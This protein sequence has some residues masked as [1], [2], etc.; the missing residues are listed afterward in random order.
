MWLPGTELQ[1]P[2]EKAPTPRQQHAGSWRALCTWEQGTQ[3]SGAVARQAEEGPAGWLLQPRRQSEGWLV[4][5]EPEALD[6]VDRKTVAM[7]H[8]SDSSDS[9]L[10]ALPLTTGRVLPFPP[11]PSWFSGAAGRGPGFLGLCPGTL[12]G[13]EMAGAS[14]R[15]KGC[16]KPCISGRDPHP[17][18][19]PARGC[20]RG[21]SLAFTSP[22]SHPRKLSARRSRH[23]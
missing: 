16:R 20:S 12:R 9:S 6:C 17:S 22:E 10:A 19:P 15:L 21:V 1:K 23:V 13:Q 14:V 2:Q 3:G 18:A 7:P 4:T 8:S 5:G 11:P